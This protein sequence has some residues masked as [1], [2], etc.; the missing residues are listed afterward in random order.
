DKFRAMAEEQYLKNVELPP[1]RGTVY[2]RTGAR[3][4]TS[5]DVDSIYVN[6]REIGDDAP[7]VAARLAKLVH[8]DRQELERR[9]ASGRYFAWVARRV[10]ADTAAAVKAQK[11][12]GVYMTKEPQRFYPSAELAGPLLGFADADARGIEGVELAHDRVLRGEHVAAPGLRDALG[13]E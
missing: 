8:V 7:D 12:D 13:R 2:D 5:A 10:K 1:R 6:P 9:L 3:L 11:L 4:A